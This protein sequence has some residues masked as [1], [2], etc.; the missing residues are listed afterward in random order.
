LVISLAE[1]F[2][3]ICY[4]AFDLVYFAFGHGV[5]CTNSSVAKSLAFQELILRM[6][7]AI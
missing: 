5:Q 4:E 2:V 1:G 7:D 3:N 6:S